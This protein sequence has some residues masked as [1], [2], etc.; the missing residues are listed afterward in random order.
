[1]VLMGSLDDQALLDRL[2]DL[3]SALRVLR[4]DARDGEATAV[5]R[6][7]Q[8]KA[9]PTA[10]IRAYW[11]GA[12]LRVLNAALNEIAV[13]MER[14]LGVKHLRAGHLKNIEIDLGDL[15]F[16]APD[17]HLDWDALCELVD[18]AAAL[19][20]KQES[21]EFNRRY[22]A[23]IRAIRVKH[24]VR[25]SD[26]AGLSER[27]INR[28]EGGEQRA[29]SKALA[30]LAAAHGIAIEDYLAAVADSMAAEG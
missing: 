12:E 8:E 6:A 1:M 22:G 16:P 11:D 24:G 25:Q 28:I 23:A 14:L 29:T 18:P 4:F 30:K 15:H 27:Q 26:V 19:R 13:P 21:D 17:I 10:I 9:S 5:A 20:A 2:R 7:L 3:P